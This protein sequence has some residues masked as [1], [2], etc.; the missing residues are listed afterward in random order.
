MP[1]PLT[2]RSLKVQTALMA[3]FG[4]AYSGGREVRPEDR[5]GSPW[6]S[7]SCLKEEPRV[8]DQAT[9]A[10]QGAAATS[11]LFC[12]WE[13]GL[14]TQDSPNSPSSWALVCRNLNSCST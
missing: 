4:S 14:D 9:S 3:S 10:Q 13:P 2:P 12:L 11:K 5:A 1:A 6:H 7:L 8:G